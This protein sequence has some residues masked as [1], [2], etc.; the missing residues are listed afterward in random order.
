MI[1]DVRAPAVKE[2]KQRGP[3]GS[4]SQ[5]SFMRRADDSSRC[6]TLQ[7][8]AGV[9]TASPSLT[10]KYSSQVRLATPAP[11]SLSSGETARNAVR[12]VAGDFVAGGAR[13]ELSARRMNDACDDDPS[14]PLCL[15][16]F[17]ADART[18]TI[19]EIFLYFTTL[20]SEIL[21]HFLSFY[22]LVNDI[23]CVCVYVCMYV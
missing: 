12:T 11:T 16:S 21:W 6:V 20:N 17:T 15:F 18:S 2:N 7:H 10:P 1:V 22:F 19:M 13:E 14:G 5:T 3:G 23:I 4:S 8:L 9:C